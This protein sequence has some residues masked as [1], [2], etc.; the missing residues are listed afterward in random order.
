MALISVPA[1]AARPLVSVIIDDMGNQ[2]REGERALALPGAVTYAFL[3]LLPATPPLA[4][5]AH[6]LGKEV[7]LHQPM[8]AVGRE[9]LGPGGIV[10]HMTHAQ[11]RRKMEANL[12]S[13]P[14]VA[15]VNNHM[16]SMITRHP[17]HMTWLMKLLK[18]HGNLYFVDSRTTA[19]TVAEQMAH[20]QRVPVVRRDVF[21]DDD[22]HPGAIRHQFHRLVAIARR[23]GHAVAIGHPHPQ[24]LKVLSRLLPQ[25]AGQGIE[26]VPV[27]AMIESVRP[28]GTMLWQ[29]SLSS[30]QKAVKRPKPSP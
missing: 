23:Q 28:K 18:R 15:G 3:P 29:A 22:L 27:S 9:P 21:L 4:R 17:G 1:L 20:E 26:L 25:L 5:R 19:R 24:T 10:L 16:G 14:F 8:E 6:R 11:F 12:A 7:M 30:S 2:M 13:V